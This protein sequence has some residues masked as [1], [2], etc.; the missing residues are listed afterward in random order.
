M[1][2]TLLLLIFSCLSF[3]L[4]AQFSLGLK[5]GA[6]IS[7]VDGISDA[8]NY[9]NFNAGVFGLFKLTKFGIQPEVLYSGQGCKIDGVELKSVYLNI[10]VMVKFYLAAGF[11]IQAGPQYGILLSAE[12]DGEDIKDQLKSS[13]MS[14]AFGLGFDA[15]FG[16]VIDARYVMGLSDINNVDGAADSYK[17]KVI[18]ISLGYKLFGK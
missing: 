2:K 4:M 12:Q 8:K 9:T 16:L 11:N 5:A 14:A 7:K 18:Q 10:P 15:P 17:N 6:N 3:H 13:D 1:K